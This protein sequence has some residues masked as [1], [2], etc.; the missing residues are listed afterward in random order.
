MHI[1]KKQFINSKKYSND[2]NR[3]M[4]KTTHRIKIFANNISGFVSRVYEGLLQLYNEDKKIL[5]IIRFS[6]VQSLSHIQLFAT[7]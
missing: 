6:S 2:I 3:K 7:P 4:R 1:C 5:K